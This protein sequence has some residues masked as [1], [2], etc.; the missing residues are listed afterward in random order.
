MVLLSH[1]DQHLKPRAGCVDCVAF[2]ESYLCEELVCDCIAHGSGDVLGVKHETAFAYSDFMVSGRGHGG[3]A[4]GGGGG[5]SEENH[6][7]RQRRID[8]KE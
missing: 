8:Y 2:M 6:C 4:Q 1:H 7:R 3:E 5:Q